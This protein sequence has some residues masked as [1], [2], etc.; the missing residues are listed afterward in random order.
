MKCMIW[1]ACDIGFTNVYMYE[2]P[3]YIALFINISAIRCSTPSIWHGQVNQTIQYNMNTPV[4][5]TCQPGYGVNDGHD[6]MGTFQCGVDTPITCDGNSNSHLHCLFTRKPATN[7]NPI[8][9][10]PMTNSV[11]M[12][13]KPHGAT[14]LRNIYN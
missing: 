4:R 11:N 6:S 1:I 5:V 9:I 8:Y 3:A 14:S 12:Y 2:I 10:C 13:T 7:I